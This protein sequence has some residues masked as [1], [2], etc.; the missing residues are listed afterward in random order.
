MSPEATPRQMVSEHTG[1]PPKQF[2]SWPR[3]VIQHIAHEAIDII[4]GPL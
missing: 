2:A 4:V 3:E 1:A